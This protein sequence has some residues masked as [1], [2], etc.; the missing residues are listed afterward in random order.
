[1]NRALCVLHDDLSSTG[2]VG[3]VL[4]ER[5]WLVD[6]LVIVPTGRHASPN[7]SQS[8][9]DADRYDLLV[10]MGAPWSAY[11]DERI[12][13][14]LIPELRWLREAAQADGAILGICFGAQALARA[15]GGSV[16]AARTPEIGWVTVDSATPGIIPSGP[17]FQWHF[18]A[19][20]PPPGSVELAR[21]AAGSQAFRT[22]R[23]LGVQFHPE[24]TS[25]GIATW[26]ENGGEAAAR[27]LG[28]DPADL[29][30]EADRQAIPS[31]ERVAALIDAY[32][33]EIFPV[34]TDNY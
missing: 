29:L 22:G 7:V 28:I 30:R 11:D 13:R 8:F 33:R 25:K 3:E 14:W 31:R 18:D 5:G 6:E 26:L 21:N 32:L 4:R 17:W 16:T 27:A 19:F 23:C 24:V 12:G 2:L 10:P 34:R 20:T 1:L 9:P 15:L